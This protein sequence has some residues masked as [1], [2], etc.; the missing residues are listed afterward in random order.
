MNDIITKKFREWTDGLGAV[1][2]RISV[3]RHIRDIPYAIVAELRDPCTGPC[4]ML[5]INKGSCVPKHFLLAKIFGMLNIPIRYVSYLFKW[6]DPLIKYPKDLRPLVRKM[7]ISAH[8]ACKAE[9]SGKWALLDA[10]WDVPL[11]KLGFPVNKNWDGS[12]DT[13]NA[14]TAISEVIH[15]T[16]DDRIRYSAELRGS[17]NK[18]DIA[19]YEEFSEKFNAWLGNARR[20]NYNNL[21]L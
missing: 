13:N 17:Y 11:I 4:K 2:S 8:L 15:E 20:E 21:L 18:E 6:D 1:D 10:T 3:F 9:I 12:S 14:V 5:E 19:V 7:P 16:L